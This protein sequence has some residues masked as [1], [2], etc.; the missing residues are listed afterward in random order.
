MMLCFVQMQYVSEASLD[1]RSY[2][3]FRYPN[4]RNLHFTVR[5]PVDLVDDTHITNLF[6]QFTS[7]CLLSSYNCNLP[8]FGSDAVFVESADYTAALASTTAKDDM[9]EADVTVIKT[10]MM[11]LLMINIDF[12]LGDIYDRDYIV[13]AE[14]IRYDNNKLTSSGVLKT[15]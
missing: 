8:N 10:S 6:E 5:I 2:R 1:E 7:F 9:Y 11:T 3:V 4:D 15:K 12:M 13:H 14:Y